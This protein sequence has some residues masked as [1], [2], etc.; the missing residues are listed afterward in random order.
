MT[1]MAGATIAPSLPQMEEVFKETAHAAFMSRL[2]LTI[3][4]LFIAILSPIAGFIIDNYGRRKTLIISLLLYAV[5]G[6]S[7]LYLKDIYTLLAGRA[8]LGV[9]VAGTMTTTI[10][11]IGDYFDGTERRRFMGYQGSFM[12]LGGVV[13]IFLGGVLADLN[14]RLPFALYFFSLLIMVMAVKFIY[15]PDRIQRKTK[16]FSLKYLKHAPPRVLLIYFTAFLGFLFF[17][18]VPMEIP[19]LLNDRTPVSSTI[20]G[21]SL[22]ISIL[23]GSVI[24]YHYGKIKKQLSYH[25]IYAFTFTMMAMG[26]GIICF[27]EIYILF[28]AGLLL[29]GLGTGLLMPNSNLWL[30]NIAPSEIRGRMIGN[31][32]FFVY[33]GQFLSPVF[34]NPLANLAGPQNGF[35]IIALIMLVF[36]A[37]FLMMKVKR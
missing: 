33:T 16:S 37:S 4:A 25:A 5:A 12:G 30:V 6:T 23:T 14:W 9:A 18:I 24:S 2:I 31:L 11:L 32:S 29:Q 10:T 20:V 28:L 26:Y 34:F 17:Y 8:L 35:G 22:G 19:F 15:E 36:A 1:I 7:G 3:P 13:F 21:L 27:A